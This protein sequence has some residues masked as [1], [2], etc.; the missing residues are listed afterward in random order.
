[1]FLGRAAVYMFL[2]GATSAWGQLR[3]SSDFTPTEKGSLGFLPA[4][5]V[6]A[7]DIK[8]VVWA[9]DGE[10]LAAVR[11]LKPITPAFIKSL[12]QGT[13]RE[14]PP[15]GEILIW[16]MQT[17]KTHSAFTF[18]PTQI[19]IFGLQWFKH[20]K[21]LLVDTRSP[22]SSNI[23]YQ[24]LY[25]VS[26]A[27]S[28]IKVLY[29]GDESHQTICNV[30]P[31]T[32]TMAYLADSEN[33]KQTLLYFMDANGNVAAPSTLEKQQVGNP[34][35]GSTAGFGSSNDGPYAYIFTKDGSQVYRYREGK[36]MELVRN[37]LE[38]PYH[39]DRQHIP[40]LWTLS[41]DSIKTGTRDLHKSSVWLTVGKDAKTQLLLT[42]DGTNAT[43]SP[44]GTG[45]SYLGEAG[46][47]VRRAVWVP[48]DFQQRQ[49]ILEDRAL[50]TKVCSE[51]DSYLSFLGKYPTST[52]W[53]LTYATQVNLTLNSPPFVYIYDGLR[54]TPQ[55]SKE[56]VIGKCT[57]TYGVAYL[58]SD[59]SIEWLPSPISQ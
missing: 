41:Y 47:L 51:V 12:T 40:A 23:G 4:E 30:S 27:D 43:I 10:R 17:G 33:G 49:A 37:S 25:L 3:F 38:M 8:K 57:T 48:R 31:S 22:A 5:L 11:E 1:M 50:A 35:M 42:A 53:E 13:P 39:A 21:F 9:D 34:V 52:E 28:S 56:T 2:L 18:D 29:R 45:V 36:P 55:N 46:L 16:N 6:C 24:T 15:H 59:H 54:I 14:D 20:S 58:H 32:D 19:K 26:T 7:P 44:Y